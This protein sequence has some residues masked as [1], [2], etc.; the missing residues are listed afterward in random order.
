MSLLGYRNLS[1]TVTLKP[2]MCL[3]DAC[4]RSDEVLQR[5]MMSEEGL[6]SHQAVTK[7]E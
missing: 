5:H 1:W 7:E 6:K 4:S 3:T 2:V